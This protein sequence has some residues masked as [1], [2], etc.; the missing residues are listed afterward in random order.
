[1]NITINNPALL[2][3][4]ISLIMLAY[5]NRFLAVAAL[6]RNLHTRYNAGEK[7]VDLPN[8]I[9]L[10]QV[11]LRLIKRMQFLGVASFIFALTSMFLMYIAVMHYALITYV[12]AV[13]LLA[14]SLVISLLEIAHST[15]ALE[16]SLK[17]MEEK[18]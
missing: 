5:T 7:E 8:Q 14:A 1:M 6:I 15:K 4:A 9:K 12:I 13:L 17:D 3:P 16:I 11:R 10:L 2:F 18:K